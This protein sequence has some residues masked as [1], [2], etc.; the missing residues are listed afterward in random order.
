M[1]IITTATYPFFIAIL[2][3][4]I[5]SLAYSII[6]EFVQRMQSAQPQPEPSFEDLSPIEKANIEA[7]EKAEKVRAQIMLE[8][9]RSTSVTEMLDQHFGD[10]RPEP[11]PE[12]PKKWWQR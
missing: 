8:R 1:A 6:K 7:Q 5:L 3:A 2:I 11:E 4:G 10:P 12:P 9:Q